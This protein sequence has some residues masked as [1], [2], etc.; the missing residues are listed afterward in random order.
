MNSFKNKEKITLDQLTYMF[1][2]E[3]M[4]ATIL[5][6]SIEMDK[7]DINTI[8]SETMIVALL[9]GQFFIMNDLSY[10]H[11]EDKERIG[12][13]V[14]RS[15]TNAFIYW[16]EK[17]DISRE[18]INENLN[19]MINYYNDLENAVSKSIDNYNKDLDEVFYLY[20]NN[21][22]FKELNINRIDDIKLQDTIATYTKRV[23]QHISIINDN[24]LNKYTILYDNNKTHITG[25]MENDVH[26]AVTKHIINSMFS[27]ETVKKN[28]RRGIIDLIITIMIIALAALLL[29]SGITSVNYRIIKIIGFILCML[30]SLLTGVMAHSG[31][32]Y[33]KFIK[34]RTQTTLK[35]HIKK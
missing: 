17:H 21:R 35:D 28:V 13:D 19:I 26:E 1:V 12:E 7:K 22:L 8:N 2:C 6:I 18:A 34:N 14:G 16:S 25:N 3:I 20:I 15:F 4:D 31:L 10:F 33:P 9:L 32:T 11:N 29:V 5:G 27:E 23:L 24:I 30:V